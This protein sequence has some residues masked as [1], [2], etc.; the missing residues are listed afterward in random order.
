MCLL[1]LRSCMMHVFSK[2]AKRVNQFSSWLTLTFYKLWKLASFLVYS[3]NIF[4]YFT[5]LWIT[6]SLDSI[7]IYFINLKNLFNFDLK[8]VITY[9]FF[10]CAFSAF[11][12]VFVFVCVWIFCTPTH[13]SACVSFEYMFTRCISSTHGASDTLVVTDGC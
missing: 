3:V 1:Y 10:F 2:L 8:I 12:F 6:L 11:R 5:F 4:S 9:C 13:V 7:F